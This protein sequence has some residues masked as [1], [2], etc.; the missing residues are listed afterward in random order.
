V[1]FNRPRRPYGG[2][3]H[4]RIARLA[5]LTTVVMSLAAVA[6]KALPA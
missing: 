6:M 1:T 3:S 4:T 5:V 2:S